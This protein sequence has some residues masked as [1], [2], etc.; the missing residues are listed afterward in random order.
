MMQLKQ[1]KQHKK[2]YFKQG[3]CTKGSKCLFEHKEREEHKVNSYESKVCKYTANNDESL[4]NHMKNKHSHE[5]LH[6]C[7]I[8]GYTANTDE[9]LGLHIKSKHTK[10]ISKESKACKN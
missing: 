7:N 3:R 10:V 6:V 5:I 8:C 4:E 1:Q 9:S 2:G